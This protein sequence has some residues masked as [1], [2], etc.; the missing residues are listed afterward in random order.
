MAS[1]HLEAMAP[2]ALQAT[3]E[4][5]GFPGTMCILEAQ[6]AALGPTL[7]EAP[8]ATEGHSTWGPTLR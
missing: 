7:R 2:L 6:V 8:G 4:V 5:Q 1:L 3:L